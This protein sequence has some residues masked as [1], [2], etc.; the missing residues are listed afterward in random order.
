[1]IQLVSGMQF[2]E[3]KRLLKCLTSQ[4]VLNLQSESFIGSLVL[5][6][7]YIQN[8]NAT[9]GVRG[10]VQTNEFWDNFGQSNRGSKNVSRSQSNTF[11]DQVSFDFTGMIWYAFG[12]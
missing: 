12:Y 5:L 2:P 11:G 4:L 8:L 1:M 9:G 6:R 3:I 10:D 7:I